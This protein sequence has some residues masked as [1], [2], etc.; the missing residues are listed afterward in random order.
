MAGAARG[1]VSVQ[2]PVT[3]TTL[4]QQLSTLNTRNPLIT[5]LELNPGG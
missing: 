3:A 4:N 5:G 1:A 2:P